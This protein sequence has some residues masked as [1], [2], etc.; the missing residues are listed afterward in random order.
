MSSSKIRQFKI[1]KLF[2]QFDVSLPLEN[3][4]NVFLGENGMGK[5]TILN[6]L[7][8]VLSGKIEKLNSVIFDTI[9]LC[10]D[11]GDC[12]SIS[13]N[14]IVSYV[15]EYVYETPFRRRRIR[16]ENVFTEKELDELR[17]SINEDNFNYQKYY[18]KVSDIYGIPLAI[19]EREL[20]HFIISYINTDKSGNYS[21][22]VEFK[23][24]IEERI[25]EEVLYFP[26]YRRIEEDISKL[27][28]D[29]EKNNVKNKLIQFGMSDV[30]D[31]INN[32]LNT[33][34][35]A[36]IT[37]FTQMT[38][39]LLKQYLQG[40]LKLE[41]DYK[42]DKEKFNIA[43]DR[44]GEEIEPA[45]KQKIKELVNTNGIYDSQ[46][47]YLLNLIKNLINSYEKQHT[48]DER[49]KKFVSVCNNY[50]NGKKYV[51]DESNV[52]LGIYKDNNKNPISIQN[53]SSG[54]KQVISVFS[55]LYLEKEEK[56]IILFDE[57]EL[58]LSIKWQSHFLPDI[59]NSNRCSTLI[60]VTH[61]PFIFDNE[62]DKYAKDMEN[63]MEES[64]KE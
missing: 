44:I 28:L 30:D 19:A 3:P 58:S 37:G 50:L 57:P 9:T 12:L 1:T 8:F 31:V 40:N 26:T 18:F 17:K 45:D 39:I 25:K 14:D 22:V 62:L 54:E 53:L 4:V 49:V 51:Y 48:Y 47:V 35:S 2:N 16:M 56:C 41:N 38:G 23:K 60:A 63:Y 5:T 13:H 61:S 43:L 64:S 11:D 29:I 46:N 27:G 33:I 59:M 10:F 7:Y 32:I 52:T 42:I 34:R 36:A 6:C 24:K 20:R 55:K 15:D 21:N